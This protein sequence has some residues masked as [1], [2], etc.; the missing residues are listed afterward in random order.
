[1]IPI[2]ETSRFPNH[3]VMYEEGALINARP[4]DDQI[5]IR[6]GFLEVLGAPRKPKLGFD[7]REGWLAYVMPNDNMFVKAFRVE[8]DRVYN[9]VAGLTVSVWYPDGPMCELEPIGPMERLKPGESAFFTETWYLL[10]QAFPRGG[11]ALDLRKV[12]AAV[13]QALDL[14]NQN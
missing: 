13:H 5:R 1:V 4:E 12:K 14:S 7:S 10:P 6:D 9:E 3:Y 8:T 11:G 2:S